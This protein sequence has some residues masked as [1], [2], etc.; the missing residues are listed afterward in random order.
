[1]TLNRRHFFLALTAGAALAG[2][3]GAVLARP[4]FGATPSGARL[5]RIRANPFW[6]GDAFRNM[7]P[8]LPRPT[9]KSWPRNMVDFLLRTN[10]GRT[11][12]QV[13]PHVPTRLA[14]VADDE[15]VWLGHSGFF[16]RTGGVSIL[17]DPALTYAAPVPGVVK[18][19]A[20]ADWFQPKDLP[21]VD[22]LLITHDHYDHLDLRVIH[23][24]RGRVGRVVTAL[25]VGA[26]FERWGWPSDLVTELEWWES[27]S[28]LSGV[29]V[30]LTPSLHFSGRGLTRNQT[31]WGGFM[32]D[33]KGW[34]GYFSGDGGMGEHFAEIAARFPSIHFAALEDGQYNIDWADIHLL[35]EYWG[36]AA[37][38]IDAAY[39]MPSHNA[40]YDLSVHGWLD[41]LNAAYDAAKQN[42]LP[43][44]L[45]RIGERLALGDLSKHDEKWWPKEP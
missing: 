37:K 4:D 13:V 15:L 43:L 42:N 11:P 27:V 41:P 14:D 5:A 25:G 12:S 1:M 45:P 36:C 26:H 18:P 32:V 33:V 28:P 31:L 7:Y 8:M 6:T 30:T 20:G 40:K 21:P 10:E 9:Q 39:T 17:I 35:P 24:M 3:A 22:L 29:E 2:T 23:A 16:L 34:R 19:F 44:V 38:I